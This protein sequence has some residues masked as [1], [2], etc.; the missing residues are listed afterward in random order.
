M[1]D[2]ACSGDTYS[3]D[4]ASQLSKLDLSSM[5]YKDFLKPIFKELTNYLVAFDEGKGP[6]VTTGFLIDPKLGFLDRMIKLSDTLASS[7]F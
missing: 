4:S 5:I 1:I 6:V 2:A 3:K 7:H